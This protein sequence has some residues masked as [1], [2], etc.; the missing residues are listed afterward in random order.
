MSLL[1]DTVLQLV[2]REYRLPAPRWAKDG[3]LLNAKDARQTL[4]KK[5]IALLEKECASD[6]EFD[7]ENTRRAMWEDWKA[8]RLQSVLRRCAYGQ[9]FVI[10]DR[11]YTADDV[12]WA[13]WGRILRMYSEGRDA[14]FRIY[15]FAKNR[16][17]RFPRF[18]AAITPSHING[19]Y[20]YPCQKD[21]VMIYRAEDATRVLIHELQHA[22]CLDDHRRGVDQVEAE[23]EA[24]AE[25]LYVALCSEGD[26]AAFHKGLQR[27]SAWIRAQNQHV[28]RW[29]GQTHAFP[30]RYTVGKEMVW[31]RWGI[32]SDTRVEQ[33]TISA[34]TRSLRLT[35]SPRP[36]ASPSSG[37]AFL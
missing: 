22:S 32:L 13:L 28:R 5:D 36:T 14:P 3:S 31:R 15:L 21:V 4:D 8:G 33:H 9:V 23:T 37:P 27:Q 17:R 16:P 10:L 12:P 24:W 11:G 25:L 19:G 34:A 29:I 18:P 2:Q 7:P 6:S 1:I 26:A 35:A 20:T 30:W